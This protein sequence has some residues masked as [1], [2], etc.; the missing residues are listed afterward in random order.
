[1]IW[2]STLNLGIAKTIYYELIEGHPNRPCLVF[3]HEGLGC[4][5]MWQD[6]PKRLCLKTGCPGLLYDRLGYGQ[7]SPLDYERTIHYVHDYALNELPG[8]LD[9]VIPDR[10]YI[11]VGHS[12]GGSIGLIYGSERSPW[13]KGIVSEAAHVFI[14]PETIEGIRVADEAF[15]RG[16]FKSLHT[17]HGPKTRQIFKAW[18]ETWLSQSFSHWNIEYLLPS[19]TCPLLVIQGRQDQYG[20]ERQVNSIVS[21][22]SG[23]AEAFL[24]DACGHA[25]H[26][27]HPDLL[28]AKISEFIAQLT[29][30]T[31]LQA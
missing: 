2:L 18:S 24:V 21:K 13:L 19:I 11:L 1:M 16:K 25:P 22:S 9:A 3:L 6:F 30:A 8:V 29:G 7:S 15:E 4:S 26:S 20:T 10:P 12:D 28:I 31:T 5:A 27:E 17:Y 23:R 14:E